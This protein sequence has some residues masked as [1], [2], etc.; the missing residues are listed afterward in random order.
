VK[1]LLLITLSLFVVSS[2]FSMQAPTE[3]RVY[4]AK[5]INPHPPVIDGVLD[6]EAWQKAEWS[7]DFV[8][9]QPYEGKEPSQ[10]TLFK[11]MYDDKNLYFSIR[12]LDTE[13]DKIERRVTRRD[14]FDGDWVEIN[15]DS[16][17]DHRTAFSF[18]LTAAGVKG[19]EAISNDGDNWD[20]NWNPIWYAGVSTDDEGWCAE[21]R[22]PFSQLRFADKGENVWGLQ[23]QRRLFRKE[24]RSVWQFIPQKTSGWVSYFGELRGI[25][26]IKPPRRIEL[27]PYSVGDVNRFQKET[28]NPFRDG[29]K[30]RLSG[31]L[32]GKIGVTSDITL[33]F[34]VNPDFG[35][36]EADPSEINLSAFETFFQEKRPFFIEGQ[37]ILDFRLMGG[38]GGFSNDRL[39]YSRRIGR[40]PH[41]D[42]DVADDEF[43][44]MPTGTSIATAF[45]LTGKTRNGLSI[46]ILDAVTDKENARFDLNGRRREEAVEPLTNYFVGRVQK[47]YN[48]GNTSIGGLLTATNRDLDSDNLQFL[49]H[50][51]YTGGID[52]RHQWNDKKYYFEFRSAFSNVRG[53]KEA[54]LELQEASAR[55]YQRPDADYVEVDSSRTSLSGHGG[56]ISFGKGGNSSVRYSVGGM[57]RSPGLDINDVGFMR[58]AD[59]AMQYTWV[60][61]RFTEPFSIFR[62]INFNF[63][64]W[65]GKNF[66][67]ETVF[68]GGNING[69]GQLKNYWQFWGGIGREG[70]NLGTSALRGGPAMKFPAQWNQWYDISTDNRKAL[71]F[72]IGGSNGWVDE[73]DSRYHN[74]RFWVSYRPHNAMSIR[75][76]PFLNINKDDLQYLQTSE[77]EDGNRYLFGRID[78]KTLGIT[79]RLNY[80]ITPNL[81]I[82]Y[83][84]QP[85]VSAGEY[86]QFKRITEPRAESYGDRYHMFAGD[87][88]RF[89]ADDEVYEIDE[90]SDGSTDYSIEQPNFNFRQFRSNLVVRWEYS[91]GSTL[92]LVWSQSRTGSESDGRFSFRNDLENLF[93][94][95]PDNVF[96]IK[97]NRW[98]S[99]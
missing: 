88:I 13:P 71:S 7:G 36:V 76:N 39:F 49:N 95:Y 5:K 30:S 97:F 73:G 70:H 33:D 41:Y 21:M 98:L 65:L 3:K 93:N 32:D 31:G 55:Y 61:L 51:A 17:F 28:G 2:A 1:K 25:N 15:I 6:D 79:L 72:G 99:L 23:V 87:E 84:G 81:S 78:Q 9:R 59:R 26:G 38:D 82:Q 66:G 69:G 67:G 16:Y 40:S 19:D 4:N 77:L 89:N 35:Q 20:S 83:Y 22:I 85:F 74:L 37:N 12:A 18:T 50:S 56:Y 60:G 68:A 52:F 29:Q 34:T 80:S 64:Q 94:V 24:E 27:L 8:Q 44:D 53:N 42:P 58:Q 91:P 11:V 47:D 46:G 96:L 57:W 10:K 75:V 92:F 86:S 63:N 48:K 62:R 54:I 14:G 45:K 90:D 43:L